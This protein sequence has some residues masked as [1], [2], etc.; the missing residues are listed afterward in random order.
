MALR[1]KFEASK[2]LAMQSSWYGVG[3]PE[4]IRKGAEKCLE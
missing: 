4:E 1:V 3:K 2:E